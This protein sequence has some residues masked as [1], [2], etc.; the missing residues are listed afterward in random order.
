MLVGRSYV[1]GAVLVGRSKEALAGHFT[2]T[3]NFLNQ[4]AMAVLPQSI[5]NIIVYNVLL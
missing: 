3:P 1:G 5:C 2:D 4:I